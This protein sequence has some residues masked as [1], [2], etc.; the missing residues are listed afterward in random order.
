MSYPDMN[1]ARETVSVVYETLNLAE[2]RIV[3][4]I[5]I[6]REPSETKAAR[7]RSGSLSNEQVV[8]VPLANINVISS[9]YN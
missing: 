4:R 3:R 9:T 6:P 7:K 2:A 8:I 1:W 5:T